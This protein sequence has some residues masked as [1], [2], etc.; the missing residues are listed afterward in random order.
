MGA[1]CGHRRG[2]P[3]IP[4]T[5]FGIPS[6]EYHCGT[7]SGAAHGEISLDTCIHSWGSWAA[8]ASGANRVFLGIFWISGEDRLGPGL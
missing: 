3:R 1:W 2:G 6:Q 5:V 4:R 7:F 8:W